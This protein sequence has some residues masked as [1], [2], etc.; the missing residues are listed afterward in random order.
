MPY[1]PPPDD[2][3]RLRMYKEFD[4]DDPRFQC[5]ILAIRVDA[6]TKEKEDIEKELVEERKARK[7]LD[8]RVAVMERSFQR[9]AGA[10]IVL[11]ILGTIIGLVFAY[12]KII[13][14]PWLKA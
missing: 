9:G 8:E 10:L 5:R 3:D 11:P 1:K 14:G 6:L 2:G 12:G 13:F 7:D 4:E